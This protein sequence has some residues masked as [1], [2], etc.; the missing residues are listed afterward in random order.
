M[1]NLMSKVSVALMAL[2]LAGY[3]V[4]TGDSPQAKRRHAVDDRGRP[5]EGR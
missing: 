2:A 1:K 3:A 4:C 5:G